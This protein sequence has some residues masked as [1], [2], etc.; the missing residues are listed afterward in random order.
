MVQSFALCPHRPNLLPAYESLESLPCPSRGLGASRLCV[1]NHT[2]AGG[3]VR[4]L[5]PCA[6]IT[7]IAFVP[8][9]SLRDLPS[10]GPEGCWLGG[11]GI[12]RVCLELNVPDYVC[13]AQVG[14][15]TKHH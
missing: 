8:G 1:P 6:Q 13:V 7:S 12:V 11:G 3:S 4:P 2:G 15:A 9:T 14:N 5:S 10:P